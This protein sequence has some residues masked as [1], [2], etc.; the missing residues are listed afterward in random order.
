MNCYQANGSGGTKSRTPPA[1]SY[2]PDGNACIPSARPNRVRIED[3][4]VSPTHP[5]PERCW[6]RRVRPG[7]EQW[8]HPGYTHRLNDPPALLRTS[9]LT[10]A[11]WDRRFSWQAA[12]GAQKLIFNDY[13]LARRVLSCGPHRNGRRFRGWPLAAHGRSFAC[14]VV[15]A[16]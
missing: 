13:E 12:V 8:C 9:S 5:H 7:C 2:P 4:L 14:L 10:A 11:G 16:T 3:D 15:S 6:R 1:A